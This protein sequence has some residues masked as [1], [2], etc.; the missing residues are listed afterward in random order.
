VNTTL[1]TNQKGFLEPGEVADEV[2]TA[3]AAGSTE[4]TLLSRSEK[5]LRSRSLPRKVRDRI[6]HDLKRVIRRLR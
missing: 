6:V 5:R 4:L 3:L 2:L 1:I